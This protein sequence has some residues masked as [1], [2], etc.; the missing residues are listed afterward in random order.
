MK[1]MLLVV[2][3]FLNL[4]IDDAPAQE[5]S[6][7]TQ[8]YTFTTIA[9]PGRGHRDGPGDQ[10]L[11][12]APEGIAVDNDGNVF[13]T[14]YNTTIVRKLSTDGLVT[15]IGGQAKRTGSK[16]GPG[17][18]SLFNR[19]HGA[20][21]DSDGGIFVSDM[22]NNQIRR[23]GRDGL[24]STL[25]GIAESSGARDGASPQA[26]FQWPEGVAVDRQGTVY[27]ADTYNFIVR[28]IDRDGIVR[29]VA[30]QASESG[31]RDGPGE[32]ARFSR[33]M[34][35][36]V[37]GQG[38]LYV[39]DANYDSPEFGN[40]LIRKISPDG[41]VSTLAGAVGQVGPNDGRGPEAR[42]HQ[43]VG[44]AVT[45][46]GVVFVADTQAD[47]I[48]RILS[49]GTVSTIGGA[50]LEEGHVDGIGGAAR[51]HDPQAIAVDTLGNL[52]IADTFNY[53]IRKGSPTKSKLG[54]R[55]NS[56]P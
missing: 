34:G 15:T 2:I 13:F 40:S 38:W 3:T 18:E 16:D 36:A 4:A 32:S 44:I 26:T 10:A 25:A 29:T 54:P 28:A 9:G 7:P 1:S 21:V 55:S 11:L 8:T 30:G 52:Y 23:I 12:G 48:R 50:Y 14:E 51:F 42:F 41:V 27:V 24:V 31:Y 33:P 22:K 19:P 45:S 20:A 6:I 35:I 46:D 39:V 56:S 53:C 37:D 43:P 47:T 5:N 17:A 49:D